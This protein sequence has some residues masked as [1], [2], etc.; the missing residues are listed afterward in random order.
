MDRKIYMRDIYPYYWIKARKKYYH[1]IPYDKNLITLIEESCQPKIILDVAIG[2]GD[3]YADYF[4]NKNIDVYGIDISQILIESCNKYNKLIKTS[5]GDAE[6]MDYSTNFFDLVYCFHST[7]YFTNVQNAVSEMIRVTKNQGYV[8]F[9]IQNLKNKYHKDAI[10]KKE[11]RKNSKLYF[12]IHKV[13]FI[14]KALWGI[15]ESWSYTIYDTPTDPDLLVDLLKNFQ[16]WI[17]G[18][19]KDDMLIQINDENDISKFQRLVYKV[20]KTK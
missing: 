3:P 14:I 1:N 10:L 12:I 13:K 11:K 16:Y 9:D 7:W 18:R 4:V 17:F 8:F 6:N 2:T 20:L 5:V 19:D 15:K